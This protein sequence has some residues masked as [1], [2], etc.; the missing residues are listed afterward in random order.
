VNGDIGKSID[1]KLDIL[2]KLLAGNLIRE[3]NKTDAIIV[4]GNCGLEV[5][6]ISEI[7]GTT[8]HRV[9]VTLYKQKKKEKLDQNK[10]DNMEE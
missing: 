7:V 3:K 4:L 9:S 10:K 5:G 8:P 1:K 6:T 2:I